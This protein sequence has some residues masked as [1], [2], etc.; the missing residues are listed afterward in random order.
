VRKEKNRIRFRGFDD[1]ETSLVF[2]F[3]IDNNFR[4]RKQPSFL[5]FSWGYELEI[6]RYTTF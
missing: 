2:G 3:E 6:D 5:E 4:V 1:I